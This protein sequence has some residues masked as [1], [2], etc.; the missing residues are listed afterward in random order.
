ME[1]S[2]KVGVARTVLV[3]AIAAVA[4]IVGVQASAGSSRSDDAGSQ[5]AGV[6]AAVHYVSAYVMQGKV[7]GGLK[8]SVKWTGPND[9]F[10]AFLKGLK[11][12]AATG[13]MNY[14]VT[15]R[16]TGALTGVGKGTLTMDV[17]TV[18]AFKPGTPL[19][20]FSTYPSAQPGTTGDPKQWL[21]GW[22]VH[23]I[24]GGTG[25]FKGASGSLNHRDIRVLMD[26]NLWGIFRIKTA[27]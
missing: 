20:D 10:D 12:N 26:A 25:A 18:A 9:G 21:G 2:M 15:E 27:A 16:F 24:I 14:R 13:V 11:Y 4:L 19:Y 17:T 5:S 6:S 22:G 1:A 8:G 3:S 23:K 7:S